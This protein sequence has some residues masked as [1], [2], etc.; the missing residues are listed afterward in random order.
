MSRPLGLT[1]QDYDELEFPRRP[2]EPA[3]PP[4]VLTLWESALFFFA[5]AA[6][7]GLVL[8]YCVSAL[9]CRVVKGR[10]PQW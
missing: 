6:C 3:A 8:A 7:L 9:L 4:I 10:W 2:A 5:C 1:Q